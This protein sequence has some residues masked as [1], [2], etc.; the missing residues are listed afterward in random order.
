MALDQADQAITSRGHSS[1]VSQVGRGVGRVA[2]GASALMRRILVLT[3]GLLGT[4]I[5]AIPGVLRSVARAARGLVRRVGDVA[6]R[7][8]HGAIGFLRRTTA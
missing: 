6:L 8:G 3:L 4:I 7:I 5:A 2:H 1:P